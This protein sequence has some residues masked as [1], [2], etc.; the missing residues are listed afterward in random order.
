MTPWWAM[1]PNHRDGSKYTEPVDV[2]KSD[3]AEWGIKN[4]GLRVFLQFGDEQSVQGI[5]RAKS[6][7]ETTL[8]KGTLS[9]EHL[10]PPPTPGIDSHPLETLF[11]VT[12]LLFHWKDALAEV[13]SPL[14]Y[15]KAFFF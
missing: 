1:S 2:Q 13:S 9:P 15:F 5:N 12:D 10:M 6:K 8:L 7:G 11:A 4:Q 3:S 14:S